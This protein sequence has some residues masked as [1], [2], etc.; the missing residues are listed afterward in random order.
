[1]QPGNLVSH[2]LT[3]SDQHA[4]VACIHNWVQRLPSNTG[5]FVEWILFRTK[6]LNFQAVCLSVSLLVVQAAT[7]QE[8]IAFFLTYHLC[9]LGLWGFCMFFH[10]HSLRTLLHALAAAWRLFL[11][12]TAWTLT[13]WRWVWSM[14]TGHARHGKGPTQTLHDLSCDPVWRTDKICLQVKHSR[15]ASL[16]LFRHFCFF[17][18]NWRCLHPYSAKY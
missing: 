9:G 14:D 17:E 16:L 12:F 11:Y 13:P 18:R 4:G 10:G 15:C 7:R 2:S 8:P 5:F 3:E 6:Q 1:M